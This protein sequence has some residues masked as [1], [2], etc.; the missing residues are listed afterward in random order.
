MP[1]LR[2][3]GEAACPPQPQR[4][5][6]ELAAAAT[7]RGRRASPSRR[8][9][10]PS[11]SSGQLVRGRAAC[12][13]T[14]S[15]RVADPAVDLPREVGAAGERRGARLGKELERL[16]ERRPGARSRSRSAS[17]TR[18]RVIGSARQRRPVAWR[19]RV[20]DRR[21]GGDD[22]RLAEA[23][24]RRRSAG[25]RRARRRSRRRSRACR[26]SSAACSRRA[27]R[28]PARPSSGRRRAPPVSANA[29][30]L[31]HAAL[32]LARG[33]EPVD[34]AA[35]V[36]D[37]DDALDANLADRRVDRDLRRSGS[38]TCGPRTPAGSGRASPSRRWSRRRAS[39]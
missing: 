16:V 32:D 8:S 26:R 23:P 27:S 3:S 36:V 9:S 28:S 31:Q 13:S 20:R 25:S 5:R 21:R 10:S 18:A 6:T 33:P 37:G 2:R 39:P 7:L 29:I 12:R 30:A 24:S 4:L 14:R 17:S 22:R 38:R 35:D 1:T 11:P 34:D 19:E 15:V